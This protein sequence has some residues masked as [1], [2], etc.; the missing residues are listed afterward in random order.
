MRLGLILLQE[1]FQAHEKA[2]GEVLKVCQVGIDVC[3]WLLDAQ[4]TV[5]DLC[6]IPCSCWFVL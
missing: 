1:V 3:F 5:V 2:Q 4:L 6:M